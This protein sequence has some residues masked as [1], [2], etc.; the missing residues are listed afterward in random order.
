MILEFAERRKPRLISHEIEEAVSCTVTEMKYDE[1]QT[2][3]TWF[4][5]TTR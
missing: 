1:L 2:E 5:P 3:K 4:L